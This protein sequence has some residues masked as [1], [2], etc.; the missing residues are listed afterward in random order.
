MEEVLFAKPNL[1]KPLGT[2]QRGASGDHDLQEHGYGRRSSTAI[3]YCIRREPNF[4]CRTVNSAPHLHQRSQPA[5]S[6]GHE[7]YANLH[8]RQVSLQY[9]GEKQA[10]SVTLDSHPASF[11]WGDNSPVNIVYCVCVACNNRKGDRTPAEARMPLLHFAE[12]ACA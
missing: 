9:C 10:A 12:A 2:V 6:I 1:T 7:A 4:R 3:A 11:A 8:A 5:R